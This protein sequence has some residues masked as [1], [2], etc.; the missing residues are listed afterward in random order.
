MKHFLIIVMLAFLSNGQAQ[1]KIEFESTAGASVLLH[2]MNFKQTELYNLYQYIGLFA[3]S[4]YD[5]KQFVDVYKIQN[6]VLQPRFGTSCLVFN[7]KLPFLLKVGIQT[8]T[9]TITEPMFNVSFGFSDKFYIT[10]NLHFRFFSGY[11][12]A[13]D[14]GWGTNTIINSIGNDAAR[15]N[16]REFF[17][18]NSLGKAQS[19]FISLNGKFQYNFLT[20][21]GL[22]IEPY[23]NIDISNYKSR[24]GRMNNF[25]VNLNLVVSLN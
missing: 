14:W 17:V 1:T 15:R 7:S 25:G 6:Y 21:Y 12:F 10:E 3:P 20:R 18:S 11:T 13:K 8:S 16:A 4:D 19:S 5:W 2:Q 9:S 24:P 22:A 23:A